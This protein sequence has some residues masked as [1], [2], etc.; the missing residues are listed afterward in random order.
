MPWSRPD[1]PVPCLTY[2][3]CLRRVVLG[4]R[5]TQKEISRVKWLSKLTGKSGRGGIVC[6]GEGTGSQIQVSCV[7]GEGLARFRRGGRDRRDKAMGRSMGYQYNKCPSRVMASM[8]GVSYSG[9]VGAVSMVVSSLWL[10]ATGK[11]CFSNK[12]LSIKLRLEATTQ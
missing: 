11:G 12:C 8:D 5:G 10:T 1:C 9:M 6:R 7:Q 4:T 2:V 3:A